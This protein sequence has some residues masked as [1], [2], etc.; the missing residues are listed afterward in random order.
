MMVMV[1][2]FLNLVFEFAGLIKFVGFVYGILYTSTVMIK[3]LMED[4]WLRERVLESRGS[5]DL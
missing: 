1:L 3:C 5:R 4:N 2:L